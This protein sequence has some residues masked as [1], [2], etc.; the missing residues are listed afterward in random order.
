VRYLT[1]AATVMTLGAALCLTGCSDEE[2]TRPTTYTADATVIQPGRPGEPATTV[3]PGETA[4]RVE[5]PGFNPADVAFVQDMIVHHSQAL[6]M[7]ELAP[8]RAADP[9]VKVLAGRI[10]AGQRPEVAVLQAWLAK[11]KQL[12][13]DPDGHGHVM[14]GMATPAQLD[15]LSDA[16]ATAFD[17][18]FLTLMINHH[19]GAVDMSTKVMTAGTDPQ[20][21]EL[22]AEISAGQSAEIN[23]ML[24]VRASLQDG[25]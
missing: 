4:R 13:T 19:Q 1:R 21:Q 11:R 16:R 9:R 2:P 5:Q 6:R 7:A 20:V 17:Q 23:R 22:A 10:A 14:S 3:A 15:A 25:P 8:Q 24:D 18:Q 12:V